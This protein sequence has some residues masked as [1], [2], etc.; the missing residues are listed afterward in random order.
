MEISLH[1][2]GTTIPIILPHEKCTTTTWGELCQDVVHNFLT[3]ADSKLML[4]IFTEIYPTERLTHYHIHYGDGN[5]SII[6]V[7]WSSSTNAPGSISLPLSSACIDVNMVLKPRVEGW[8]QNLSK[9]HLPVQPVGIVS[10]PS[11]LHVDLCFSV[12]SSAEPPFPYNEDRMSVLYLKE[13]AVYAG[14]VDTYE[15]MAAEDGFH[16]LL[17]TVT[18]VPQEVSSAAAAISADTPIATGKK[19]Q[20]PSTASSLEESQAKISKKREEGEGSSKSDSNSDVIMEEPADKYDTS[21][22]GELKSIVDP[23]FSEKYP[24][25]MEAAF[26]VLD[27]L[28]LHPSHAPWVEGAGFLLAAE[29]CYGNEAIMNMHRDHYLRQSFGK[30]DLSSIPVDDNTRECF[31]YGVGYGSSTFGTVAE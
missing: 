13:H 10:F 7:D 16:D 4:K 29:S 12:A 20:A 17:P 8:L 11:T 26:K 22:R 23:S 9:P 6:R 5:S 2:A 1:A 25:V 28:Y 18:R 15:I 24:G 30:T 27:Y 14:C 3:A 21:N 19:R 31:V